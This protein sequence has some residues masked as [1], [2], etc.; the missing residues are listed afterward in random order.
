MTSLVI[1]GYWAQ[2]EIDWGDLNDDDLV[3]ALRQLP[4]SLQRLDVVLELTSEPEFPR[5]YLEKAIRLNV[6]VEFLTVRVRDGEW[7]EMRHIGLETE[8]G[9]DSLAYPFVPSC[10]TEMRALMR[11]VDALKSAARV[12]GIAIHCCACCVGS[13]L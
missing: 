5:G 12:S 7:A 3:D 4:P 1:A 2:A 10:Q 9:L 6:L 8:F 11:N 13:S